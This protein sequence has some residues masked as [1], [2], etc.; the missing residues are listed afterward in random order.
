MRIIP[1]LSVLAFFT[2]AVS[3]EKGTVEIPLT[4]WEHMVDAIDS[5][6][7]AGHADQGYCPIS[8]SI[9]GAF[10]RGM[11]KGVLFARFTV[12]DSGHIRIPVI[13]G[14]ATLGVVTLNGTRTSLYRENAMFTAGVEKPG[15]YAIRAEIIWG[16]EVD[17]FERELAFLLPEAGPTKVSID[18]PERGIDATLKN[19]ALL[20]A[21]EHG[22]STRI[23][24]NLDAS[25]KFDLLWNRR[26]S[27]TAKSLASEVKLFSIFTVQEALVTGQSLFRITILEGEADRIDL[28]LPKEIEIVDVS[29]NVVL[30]WRTDPRDGGRLIVLLRHLVQDQVSFT[31]RFQF[32]IKDGKEIP[33]AMPLP[34]SATAMTGS[35]GILS[36][37]GLNVRIIKADSAAEMELR[38]LPPD[39][40]DMAS[41]PFLYGFSFSS[42]PKVRLSVTRHKEVSL[43]ETIID[44]LEAST[45]VIQ[46]GL[47]ITKMK[48]RIRNN[49][50]Q[51]LNMVLPAG[52]HLTHSMIDGMPVRPALIKKGGRDV[53]LFPLQQSEPISQVTGQYHFV[54]SGETLSDI[55]NRYYSDPTMWQFIL[56]ENENLLASADDLMEGQRLRIAPRH[57]VTIR[58][59]SFFIELA[60]QRKSSKPLGWIG[61]RSFTLPKVDVETVEAV[62]HLY[63]PQVLDPIAFRSNMTQLTAIRYGLFTRLR[64]FA[65]SALW[66]KAWAG[67][68]LEYS[69]ILVQ[70][71]A[72][73]KADYAKRSREETVLASFPFVGQKYR[74]R[75]NLIGSETPR[76]SLF[77]IPHWLG[78][79]M[80]WLGFIAGFCAV[81]IVMS[82]WKNR[83]TMILTGCGA[84]AFLILA[85]YFLGMHRR[86]LWG[87]DAALL[88]SILKMKWPSLQALILA[89]AREPW[90]F[91]KI[92]RWGN[93]AIVAV[94]SLF[95]AL[96]LALPMFFSSFLLILLILWRWRQRRL[97][98]G[99]SLKSNTITAFVLL[100]CLFI[101]IPSGYSQNDFED[102]FQEVDR[103][104]QA[105]GVSQNAATNGS[106]EPAQ[107]EQAKDAESD[108][109]FDAI[110]KNQARQAQ[111]PAPLSEYQGVAEKAEKQPLVKMSLDEYNKLRRKIN[112]IALRSSAPK[113]PAVILGASE[114][115]GK[116]V[117]GSL[118]LRLKLRVTLGYPGTWKTVPI[119][120]DD[121][122]LVSA[123]VKGQPIPVSRQNKYHVWITDKAG[124]IEIEANIL[125]PSQGP[126]GS[127]EY[128]FRAVRTPATTFACEFPLEGLEPQLNAALRSESK[129]MP[130]ITRFFATLRT[131]SRIHL[132]GFKEMGESDRQ[133][134]KVYAETK[135]LL[136]IDE[137]ALE[138][139]SVF[140]YTILYSG[141]QK[142]TIFIPQGSKV[143]SADGRG[144]FR[145]SLEPADS[146]V[147]MVGET[148]FPI[149]NNFELSLRLRRE[150]KKNGE[151]FTVPLPRCRGVERESGWLG[152]EVPGKLQLEEKSARDMLA[153]D[154]RQ[155]PDELLRSAVSPI[156]RAYQYHS[157]AAQVRLFASTLP[158]IEPASGSIDNIQAFTQITDKG[159]VL[160]DMRLTLRNRLRHSIVMK[161]P[162]GAEALS[163][164]IDGQPLN[165]SRDSMERILLP[166][167]R[168]AGGEQLQPF[169]VSIVLKRN[170]R[171]LKWFGFP[172]IGLPS[173][174]MPV[175]SMTWHVYVPGFNTYSKL[176][177]D[178]D[179]Q[180]YAGQ[181]A[182]QQPPFEQTFDEP[183]L[184]G[185]TYGNEAF[186]PSPISGGAM[187]VQVKIP[188]HGK[189]LVYTRYWI[190]NDK[191]IKV[192]FDFIRSSLLLPMQLFIVLL[193][194][195][196][197]FFCFKGRRF[198][199]LFGTAVA[200]LPI[201]L[202]AG[203]WLGKIAVPLIG[204]LAGVTA[205]GI[206]G[207]WHA[208]VAA[209]VKNV[210]SRFRDRE[211]IKVKKSFMTIIREEARY[212]TFVIIGI[213]FLIMVNS[214]VHLILDHPL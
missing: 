141:A 159:V 114:Y 107:S 203:Y 95:I 90:T 85:Y 45:V 117:H 150:L 167:K 16:K 46:D 102:E 197:L 121:A 24:G 129:R 131:T 57:G 112:E 2:M 206:S 84:V 70:R 202:A 183:S 201:G 120:G 191:P 51:Y 25:G 69:N 199:I 42:P 81:F 58:E 21:V 147:I 79:P 176:H 72:I 136:S 135:N 196:A 173:V 19:G 11:F 189:E 82:Q 138:L 17:R 44:D 28:R 194:A 99:S 68:G 6:K 205:V 111:T 179:L 8:R 113:G 47:E 207:R 88:I 96:V 52:T 143:M 213:V 23:E 204:L 77:Y 37:S 148:E 7:R 36:T 158:E 56:K 208:G 1:L 64:D 92:V 161:L 86:I 80:A 93:I 97:R 164:M 30:Q 163:A 43:T 185:G 5:S 210:P 174:D 181:A 140:N 61:A 38:D 122:V 12:F 123:T 119:A 177:G 10:H 22:T 50:R 106:D 67:G 133:P 29:G 78:G 71:K 32:P 98:G 187:P 142:F 87:A 103:G 55:A 171:T 105:Q 126:R 104:Y 101:F 26:L 169:T 153:I 91:M 39:L 66:K 151:V 33:L 49:N 200:L 41:N 139:F 184:L 211:K 9:E 63:F 193:I 128:D 18:L 180:Q 109:Y 89:F 178:I 190:E 118:A 209:W 172:T 125:V 155:L 115:S 152:I 124:E 31:V 130:G 186:N 182:W 168:S 144:A 75:R 108:Y 156:L 134:A 40:T 146:G 13:D 127:I 73:Y 137:N 145:Y 62:W 34:D 53:L 76:I 116:T 170:G 162:Q 83:R 165:V 20:S 214:L 35:L 160:T 100:C 4:T 132:I 188:L 212:L 149:R 110:M 195:A 175:S 166:L 157:P 65:Q 60:Y 192:S 48:L 54:R 59:S 154:M 3:E 27:H 14:N 74:F 15:T 198:R 94:I